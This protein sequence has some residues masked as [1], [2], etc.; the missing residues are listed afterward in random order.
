MYKYILL[1][2]LILVICIFIKYN[3][4]ENFYEDKI[5]KLIIQTWKTDDIPKKYIED[6]KSLKKL[7]PDFEFK[8][9]TDQQ[10]EQFLK[11]YYPKHYETYKKL[12]IKIQKID[13]FRYVAIYHYGGFYFDLDI[14]GLQ[15]LKPLC[16]Y[17]CVFP[18]DLHINKNMCNEGRYI[19]FCND[20]IDYLIGQYAFSATPK[21]PFIKLLIDSI[22]KNLQEYLNDYN[23]KYGE[24]HEYVYKSTGPDFVTDMYH[25]YPD[26]NTIK[27]LHHNKG[28]Y[29]GDYAKHNY[30]GTWK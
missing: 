26:K 1:V 7:N 9:F 19:D 28:Q 3:S 24:T 16:K 2:L 11:I 22:D 18:I 8:L 12:P 14:T 20:K 29:F 30:Y 13:Y 27:I 21:H 25:L 4:I 10:I 5:P 6:I 15:S 17:E 23:T